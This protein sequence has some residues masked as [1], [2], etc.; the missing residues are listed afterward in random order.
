MNQLIHQG[1]KVLIALCLLP[2]CTVFRPNRDNGKIGVTFVQVN[3]VYEIAPLAGGKEGGMARVATLKARTQRGNP[4]TM[5][6]MAGDFV[7][8]S[9]FNSLSHEGTRIRG[10]QMIEAMNA[11]GV[12]LAVF[13]NHEFDINER[14]LQSRLD[15]SRFDWVASNTFH[16]RGDT[17]RPFRRSGATSFPFPERRILYFRDGD[18]TELRVG[19][20]GLTQALNRAAYVHYLD[21]IEQ[22]RAVWESLKDSTDVII[23]LTHMELA[24]DRRLAQALP[25]LALILGGH[26]HDRKEERVGNT[27]ITKAH[28]NAKSAYVVELEF[29]RRRG[30]VSTDAD[31]VYLNETVPLDSATH[32]V[33]QQWGAVAAANLA[34]LG[35]DA[36]ATVAAGSEVLDGKET[37][38]RHRATNLTR[39]IIRAME[40]AV[41]GAQV[42]LFNGGSI[43]VDDELPPPVTQYDIVRAMPF[44]GGIQEVDMKGALLLQVLEAGRKNEGNGGFLHYSA[45]LKWEGGRWLLNGQAVEES[46]TYRV[47]LPDFLLTGGEIN[48]SF[49]TAKNEGIVKVYPRAETD[50]V[51]NDIRRALIRSVQ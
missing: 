6:V 48:M 49:L 15:E 16:K 47:A 32:R 13:G 28:A 2:A 29:N 42:A 27:L 40:K 17:V 8:P 50:Q 22:A 45:A 36:G 23:A 46:R 1:T 5:L 24:E 44:G 35:F 10:R 3:D 9:V 43:R 31:L 39:L 21:P 7:S 25:G 51:R 14:E 38:V 33:V 20:I 12:D 19:V 18:G 11:A 26:E 4:N 41:P 34:T 37:S 30:R